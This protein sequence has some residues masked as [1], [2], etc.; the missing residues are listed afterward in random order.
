MNRNEVV[1]AIV[2]AIQDDGDASCEF[3][4]G[5]NRETAELALTAL[6]AIMER[7]GVKMLDGYMP[8]APTSRSAMMQE[9]QFKECFDQAKCKMRGE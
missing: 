2:E 8:T 1:E 5:M 7:D 6:E 4:N 3:T 9:Q